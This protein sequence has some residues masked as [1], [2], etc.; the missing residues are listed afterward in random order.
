MTKQLLAPLL[1]LLAT[2]LVFYLE[3]LRKQAIHFNWCVESNQ[4]TKN[5]HSKMVNYCNGGEWFEP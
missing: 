3:P 5:S 2:C 4:G 1:I